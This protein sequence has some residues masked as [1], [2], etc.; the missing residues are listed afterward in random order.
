LLDPVR[1]LDLE[2]SFW[3]D[4][5]QSA[6]ALELHDRALAEGREALR[7]R[8]LLNR[9][10]T[11]EVMGNSEAALSDLAEA[12]PAIDQAEAQRE[13]LVLRFNLVVNFLNLG[14]AEEARTLLPQVRALAVQLG[15]ELDLLRL[16][17]LEGRVAEAFGHSGE[18]VVAYESLIG[19]FGRLNQGADAA[20]AGLEAAALH[21]EAGRH[22]RVKRLAADLI[23]LFGAYGLEG[24]ELAS[25][26]LFLEAAE[27]ESATAAL[28][29]EAARAWVRSRGSHR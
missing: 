29:R 2:A 16:R 19:E 22:G 4:Q 24:E 27:H 1:L 11:L 5:R 20:L 21:L 23:P 6:R 9:A 17:W 18:A 26:R 12:L 13:R 28:A 8:L 3:R 15:R 7:G 10:F 25:V 14:R